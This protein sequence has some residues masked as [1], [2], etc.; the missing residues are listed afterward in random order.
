LSARHRTPGIFSSFQFDSPLETFGE[1]QISGSSRH[2]SRDLEISQN[3]EWTFL[4]AQPVPERPK[5]INEWLKG[6]VLV[7]EL[8][9]MPFKENSEESMIIEYSP[10][11]SESESTSDFAKLRTV[12]IEGSENF[13]LEHSDTTMEVDVEGLLLCETPHKTLLQVMAFP[14]MA[15]AFPH[16][17]EVFQMPPFI[18]A[19]LCFERMNRVNRE[20]GT[21]RSD[22]T[23][24][25]QVLCFW[26]PQLD[27]MA[28]WLWELRQMHQGIAH[29]LEQ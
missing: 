4:A 14:E 15:I 27:M 23:T 13:M 2:C 3:G 26:Q 18:P 5:E 22:Y 24:V 25:R 7:P 28:T 11:T 29:R 19:D 17:E 8:L 9:L 1:D 21:L 16:E 12:T 20:L 6:T 10:E